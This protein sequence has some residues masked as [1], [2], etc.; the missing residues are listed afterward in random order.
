MV[1]TSMLRPT[2]SEP[3]G[4]NML[5]Q[6]QVRVWVCVWVRVIHFRDTQAVI[7]LQIRSCAALSWGATGHGL[8]GLA[9]AYTFSFGY[10]DMQCS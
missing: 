3:L 7:H 6:L 4:H 9:T 10:E 8:E 5:R 1:L 2:F